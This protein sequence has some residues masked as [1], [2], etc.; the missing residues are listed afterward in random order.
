V[1]PAF[2]RRLVG[3][4]LVALVAVLAAGA[5][6]TATTIAAPGETPD[7]FARTVSD[8]PGTGLREKRL[9]ELP[10][11]WP[12]GPITTS[13]GEK[14]TVYVSPSLGPSVTP[15]SWAEFFAHLTHGPELSLLTAYLG[16]LD[17]VQQICG[18]QALGCYGDNQLV[19]LG[20]PAI[21][22]TTPEEIVRHEYGHHI[23][24]NRLNPPWTAIDWGPKDWA[25]AAGICRRV[26]Q[27]SAFP[28]D[29]SVHYDQN[30]GEAWAE[31][32]RLMDERKNG[33]NT[34][35]WSIVSRSFFP[36]EADF[37]AAEEDV[38]H[39]WT[40]GHSAAFR[41]QLTKK[42]KKVWLIRLQT[43]LDG[44]LTV[45]AVLPK[46][47]LAD[48][49]LLSTNGKTVLRHATFVRSR[50]KQLTT[51]VCGQRSLSVRVTP[52]GSPG[53]VTV[54]MATP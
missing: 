4:V 15:Q 53:P 6:V 19:A 34:Q 3:I 54:T 24:F 14:V 25:S 40:A 28:G 38:V 51:T 48:V 42:S 39:P 20:Q 11:D 35:N 47:S 8:P 12:G 36:S 13:T 44:M 45:S 37:A 31:T 9:A 2:L 46:G 41:K 52:K 23:A 49:A 7:L 10:A 17:E 32:Y 33:I 22:G 18:A 30:P 21:D 43:P 1:P 26:N 16:T 27:G 29:E 50:T 5:G